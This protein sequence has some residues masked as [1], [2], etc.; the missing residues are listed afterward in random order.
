MKL[1]YVVQEEVSVKQRQCTDAVQEDHREKYFS[2]FGHLWKFHKASWCPQNITSVAVGLFLNVHHASRWSQNI[3]NQYENNEKLWRRRLLYSLLF[4]DF[5]TRVSMV[6]K[7][8]K[9][10]EGEDCP[11]VLYLQKFHQALYNFLPIQ[12]KL[13]Q[14][15]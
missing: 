5:S 14:F 11:L 4:V 2:V 12:R 3:G 15:F 9:K 13:K 1:L 6:T 7:C 10:Q 8:R